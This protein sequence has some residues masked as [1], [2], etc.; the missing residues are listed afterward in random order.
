MNIERLKVTH[1]HLPFHRNFWIAIAWM[2]VWKATPL[3]YHISY[4]PLLEPD[5]L[6]QSQ[7]KLATLKVYK[8][9]KSVRTNVQQICEKHTNTITNLTLRTCHTPSRPPRS[10]PL[11]VWTL[12]SLSTPF[13]I[14]Y[15]SATSRPPSSI[16]RQC[17]FGY[18]TVCPYLYQ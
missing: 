11:I 1:S 5:P 18:W 13:I 16:K 10:I 12:H 4:W 7:A 6:T 14:C 9:V 17:D 15:T 8:K 3:K 2:I